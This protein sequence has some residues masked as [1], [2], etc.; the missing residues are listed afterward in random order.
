M[1]I[2]GGGAEEAAEKLRGMAKRKT[3]DLRADGI[4]TGPASGKWG[5]WCW[6]T[7]GVCLD[8]GEENREVE[9]EV[10]RKMVFPALSRR[11]IE[12]GVS[13]HLG[14]EIVGFDRGCGAE[15]YASA[16]DRLRLVWHGGSVPWWVVLSGE[17]AKTLPPGKS[18][19]QNRSQSRWDLVVDEDEAGPD[20]T[21]VLRAEGDA[22]QGRI[23]SLVLAPDRIE[24]ASPSPTWS[25]SKS[26]KTARGT[27][28]GSAKGTP[29]RGGPAKGN[30]SYLGGSLP[31]TPKLLNASKQLSFADDATST[32]PPE[33]GNTT[34]SSHG[35]ATPSSRQGSLRRSN[36]KASVLS[37]DKG[38]FKGVPQLVSV[39]G[40]ED[41]C[42]CNLEFLKC[43]S[44]SV[45]RFCVHVC[46]LTCALVLRMARQQK[47]VRGSKRYSNCAS[48]EDL[49]MARIQSAVAGGTDGT[50]AA[51]WMS[52]G[53]RV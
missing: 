52:L 41:R 13:V 18:I 15:T 19:E 12:E 31:G 14:Y 25:P 43:I 21:S 28:I 3:S 20:T 36:S 35:N 45:R 40:L 1:W 42:S 46:M 8:E 10:L 37:Y 53:F 5:S 49:M 27:P 39:G 17:M 50:R 44:S 30:A 26:S 33:V 23:E 48:I 24:T 2:K 47:R 11:C 32:P 9:L 51:T 29:M 16:L 4:I 38:S 22:L 7:V 6:A 34:P